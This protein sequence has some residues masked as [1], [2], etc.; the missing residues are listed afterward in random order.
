MKMETIVS[1]E[2]GERRWKHVHIKR[3]VGVG[4]GWNVIR[5]YLIGGKLGWEFISWFSWRFEMR[6]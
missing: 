1:G 6:E 5:D 4:A 2:G 3:G